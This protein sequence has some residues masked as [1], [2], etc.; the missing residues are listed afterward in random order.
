MTESSLI[1]VIVAG[2]LGKLG[3]LLGSLVTSRAVARGP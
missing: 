3:A 2:L 1:T